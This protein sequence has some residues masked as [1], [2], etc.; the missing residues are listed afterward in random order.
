[1][2][3]LAARCARHPGRVIAC[4][5]VLFAIAYCLTVVLFPK[6]DGR[7]VVGD[8]V[9]YFVYL[10]SLVFDHDL[11]FQ[12][13]YIRLYRLTPP[14]PPDTEWVFTP[15]PTGYTRN[16]MPIGPALVWAP[17]YLLTTAGAWLLHLAGLAEPADGFSRV[18]QAT[19]ALSGIG[20]ATLGAWLAFGLARDLVGPVLALW[21]TLAV[22]LGSSALYYS[23]VSPTYSHAASMLVTSLTIYAW[24]RTRH[25]RTITRYAMVGGLVG[26]ATLVRPQ[27]VVFLA[28]PLL[29]AVGD[30]RAGDGGAE[31]RWLTAGAR[32]LAACGAAAIVFSPQM[33]VWSTIYGSVLL[34][35][36]GSGFMRWS[37]PH[38]LAVLFSTTRGLFTWT[39]VLLIAVFGLYRLGVAHRHLGMTLGVIFV[40]SC[41]VNAAVADWWAGEAFGARRFVSCFPRFVAGTAVVLA[42]W[43]DRPAWC[44]SAAVL[45]IA[46]NMLLLLQ[47]QLYLKGWRD[48]AP[49]PDDFWSLWIARFVVPFRV[50]ARVAGAE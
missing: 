36:Q 3:W 34:V 41:Y 48:L 16:V 45:V 12:N 40:L 30:A 1:V 33:M 19:A 10:R 29:D 24:W 6:P 37:E 39:P 47:Y 7:V 25:R 35:P 22:W 46:L 21:A 38:L 13:E 32:A 42:R 2:K 50:L 8:A 43:R 17:L 31:R 27:D 26:L 4:T 20:A 15:L 23:L 11:H 49:Y 9:H 14:P 18:F 5:G 44:A 28:A